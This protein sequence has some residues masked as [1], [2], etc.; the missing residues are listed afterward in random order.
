MYSILI[1]KMDALY[2]STNSMDDQRGL[3]NQFYNINVSKRIK[4]GLS[5][6]QGLGDMNNQ[7][8]MNTDESNSFNGVKEDEF[9][10]EQDKYDVVIADSMRIMIFNHFQI[11]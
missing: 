1:N 8:H 2:S 10:F 3:Q 4:N 9:L 7:I 11:R 6:S 5:K